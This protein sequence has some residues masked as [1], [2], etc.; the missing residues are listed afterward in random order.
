[1]DLLLLFVILLVV[2]VGYIN[3]KVSLLIVQST[4]ES[5]LIR[6]FALMVVWCLPVL[7]A[8]L[9]PKTLLPSIRVSHKRKVLLTGGDL[10]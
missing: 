2:V 7:G 3:L 8:F 6:F 10:G 9:V 1:M 5:V 4:S